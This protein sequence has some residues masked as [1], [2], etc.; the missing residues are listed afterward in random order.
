MHSFMNKDKLIF[1]PNEII[2]DHQ[3]PQ[4]SLSY[5]EYAGVYGMPP[6]PPEYVIYSK[7]FDRYDHP[8]SLYQPEAG[9]T[10]QYQ[11]ELLKSEYNEL[12]KKSTGYV[13]YV[14]QKVANEFE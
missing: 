5:S 13:P 1:G 9:K 11:L 6:P 2:F 7:N 4:R 12:M 14:P 8:G 3:N 10:S